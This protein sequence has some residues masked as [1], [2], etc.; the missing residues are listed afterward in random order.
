MKDG[1][2]SVFIV[3]LDDMIITRDDIQEI[4]DLKKRL[5]VEIKDLGTVWY[6]LGM[7]EARSK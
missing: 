2:K 7:E 5:R 1:K 6:F 4:K 3:Y